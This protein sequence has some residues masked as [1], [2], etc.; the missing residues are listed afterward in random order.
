MEERKY[1]TGSLF[2]YNDKLFYEEKWKGKKKLKIIIGT[3]Y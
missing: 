2:F 1:L 3:V